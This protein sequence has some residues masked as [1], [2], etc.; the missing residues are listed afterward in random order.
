[1]RQWR[2]YG[3]RGDFEAFVT[4]FRGRAHPVDDIA[5]FLSSHLKV[6]RADLSNDAD[7][8]PLDVRGTFTELWRERKRVRPGQ[9]EED[10]DVLLR[11]DVEM[12]LGV[13]G[14]RKEA[15]RGLFGFTDWWLTADASA[16]AMAKVARKNGIDLG[17]SPA[18]HPEFLG[19]VLTVGTATRDSLSHARRLLPV[20]LNI[21]HQGWGVPELSELAT[22]IRMANSGDPEWVIRRK[23][24][25]SADQLR[26]TDRW[27]VVPVPGEDTLVAEET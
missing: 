6:R 26:A 2:D 22:R 13:L 14:R 21:Q 7:A 10:V 5:D 16:F 17:S 9:D 15:D 24:R 18:M 23:I 19:S 4:K 1:L 25:D 20:A 8:F 3:G 11:H 27:R 12:Y